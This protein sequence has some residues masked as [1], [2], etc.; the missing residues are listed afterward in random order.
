VRGHVAGETQAPGE[1]RG[2]GREIRAVRPAAQPPGDEPGRS[3]S[4]RGFSDS[5]HGYV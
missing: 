4:G 1:V 2:H 3:G 5:T